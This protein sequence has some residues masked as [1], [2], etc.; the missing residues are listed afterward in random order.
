ME[1]ASLAQVS[2]PKISLVFSFGI[3]ISQSIARYKLFLVS[4][5][6][7]LQGVE[8][9]NGISWS[10][11]GTNCKSMPNL[12]PTPNKMYPEKCD[13]V[14]GQAYTLQCKNTGDS[15]KTNY[16]IFE[17]SAYCK[18]ARTTTLLNITITGGV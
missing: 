18:Y 1:A 6:I 8:E 11:L 10:L 9:T 12:Q 5:I 14:M 16:L 4:A 13:L 3:F 17:N 15:W 7:E 2:I